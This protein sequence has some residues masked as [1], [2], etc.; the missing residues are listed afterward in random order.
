[1][2]GLVGIVIGF[3]SVAAQGQDSGIFEVRGVN[4]DVT[5]ASTDAAR[6]KARMQGES[7]AFDTLLKRLTMRVHQ[8]GLPKFSSGELLST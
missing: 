6:D 8:S 3:L 5:A 7:T 2:A 4:V 1:M